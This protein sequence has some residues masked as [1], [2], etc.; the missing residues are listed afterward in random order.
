M[1]RPR[2]MRAIENNTSGLEKV[3]KVLGTAVMLS[4]TLIIGLFGFVLLLGIYYAMEAEN[5]NLLGFC[6]FLLF[7]PILL[8]IVFGCLSLAEAVRKEL[9]VREDPSS[10]SWWDTRQGFRVLYQAYYL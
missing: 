5:Q 9:T 6:C 2:A 10:P 7:S 4:W 8:T 1:R 3:V